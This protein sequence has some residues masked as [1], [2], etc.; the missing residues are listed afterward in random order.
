MYVYDTL[1]KEKKLFKPLHDDFARM[2]SCG[3]T[4]YDFDH[5]GHAWKYT[6]D[7]LLRRVLEYNN[8]SVNHVMNITDVGHL[9]S[10]ADTGEDKIEK[11]A[12]ESGKSAWDIARYYESIFLENKRL[13]N[14]IPPTTLCRATEHIPQMIDLVKKLEDMGATYTTSDGIYFDLS[15]FPYY[16]KLS[17]NSL[18]K[19][20]AGAR[21]E[22]NSEKKSPLDFALWKFSKTAGKR[23]M[24]W[25]SPWGVGFPGWHIECSAMSMYYLGPQ[26]DF[27]T[28]GEDNIFPHHECEI[29]QSELVTGK[30]FSQFWVHTRFLTVDGEKMSKSKHN[31]FTL[32]EIIDKGL[33]PLALRYLF[34]GSHYRTG[35][36]FTWQSLEAAQ[37][38]LNRIR[39]H[40]LRYSQALLSSESQKSLLEDKFTK[41]FHQAV[42]DDLNMPVAI[43]VVWEVIKSSLKDSEKLTTILAFDKVLG[44]KLDENTTPKTALPVQVTG[45]VAEREAAKRLNDWARSDALRNEITALGYTVEDTSGG[46]RVLPN[47]Q[48]RG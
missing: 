8:F 42:N 32:K 27:H 48:K 33:D 24:E 28:G 38:S 39:G 16:G 37:T 10:D 12:Q 11:K 4:V 22:I 21:V 35:L 46:Q 29:A 6:V 3:P 1:A 15:K 25:N 30:Q 23:A 40:V 47:L 26:L 7:D 13:L 19:L 20:M 17:G 5:I 9:V 34:L 43:S 41:K 44:L 36:N 18:D 2:Y 14:Q 31:F 45:L